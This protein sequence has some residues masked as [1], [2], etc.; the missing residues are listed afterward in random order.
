MEL[1]S[2]VFVYGTLKQGRG[3]HRILETSKLI[4]SAE[5]VKEF[6]M[7]S[8]GMF[9][10][11]VPDNKLPTKIKGEVYEVTDPEVARRLD[12]LEGYPSFYDRQEVSVLDEDGNEHTAWMYFIHRSSGWSVV[13][14]GEW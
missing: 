2:K 14:S 5:T 12:R 7:Y 10:A 11:V 1:P 9:P 8:L 6:T 3:N 4:N 13:E